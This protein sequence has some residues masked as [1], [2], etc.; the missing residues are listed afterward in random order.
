MIAEYELSGS[1]PT[2]ETIT[3]RFDR[4]GVKHKMMGESS[5]KNILRNISYQEVIQ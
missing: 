5:T 4:L 2:I 3:N 1:L